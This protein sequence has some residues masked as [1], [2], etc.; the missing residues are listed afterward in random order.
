VCS[1]L[2]DDLDQ[3]YL[4]CSKAIDAV[5]QRFSNVT[6]TADYTGGTKS[7]S[8]ALVMAALEFPNVNLQL[9]SGSRSDL[10]KVLIVA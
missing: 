6:I 1:T 2:A 7:M 8:A 3:I 4:D 9:V 10:I 5:V